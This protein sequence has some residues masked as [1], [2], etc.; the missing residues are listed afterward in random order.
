MLTKPFPCNDIDPL[1]SSIYE[2]ILN[3]KTS[4]A[5]AGFQRGVN[6]VLVKGN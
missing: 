3:L 5:G 2:P 1:F 4:D 6:A